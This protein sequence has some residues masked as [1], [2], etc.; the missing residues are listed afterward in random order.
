V[1]GA[2]IVPQSTGDTL[3]DDIIGLAGREPG[4]VRVAIIVG[5]HDLFQTT[6]LDPLKRVHTPGR[7]DTSGCLV[8]ADRVIVDGFKSDS[9]CSD[10]FDEP[11]C[12]PVVDLPSSVSVANGV[13]NIGLTQVPLVKTEHGMSSPNEAF[14][15]HR[16]GFYV[17]ILPTR[18]HKDA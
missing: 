5:V 6:V 11:I 4:D 7:H 13:L 16:A 10:A 15:R 14:D 1:G 17:A 18:A 3:A 2:I 12:L 9:V 8:V